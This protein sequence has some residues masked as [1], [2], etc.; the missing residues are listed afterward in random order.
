MVLVL[1]ADVPLIGAASLRRLLEAG[2]GDPALL[3]VRLADP[4]GYGRI[5]REDGDAVARIVEERD[6]TAGERAVDEVNTG[7]MALPA[8]PL[9]RW[10]G[11]LSSDNAQG[12]YY[13]TDVVAMAR[14]D[15]LTVHAL[16]VADPHEVQGVNT[17]AQLAVLERVWQ[18]RQA[19]RLMAGGVTLLD[20]ARIDVRGELRCGID[21]TIDVNC[22]F[23]GSVELADGVHIG[24]NC[25]LRDCRLGPGAVVEGFSVLEGADIDRDGLVGPFARMRPGTRLDRGAKVGNFVEIKQS[26]VGPGSKVNH[27]SY[28]GDT[29]I[30]ERVNVGAGTITCNYDGARKHETVIEDDAFIGSDTQLVAP[31]TVGRGATIGAGTTVTRDVPAEQ[32][33]LSRVPQKLVEGWERPRK[34][35]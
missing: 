35:K 5:L 4:S 20:P 10:L 24:P 31:V 16:E 25:L 9:R 22:V 6:A 18:R 11:A 21:V 13:L 1:C 14:R 26:R 30:G 28:I 7:L 3:T 12:E 23:E 34:D 15:G 32:L 27:L 17:R 19:D 29:R 8:A 2:G 33:A